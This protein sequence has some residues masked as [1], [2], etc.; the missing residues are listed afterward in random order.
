MLV[1]EDALDIG[2]VAAIHCFCKSG[3]QKPINAVGQIP[4]KA[5][6]RLSSCLF[7]QKW[8]GLAGHFLTAIIT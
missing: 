5:V 1:S 3:E 4:I 8:L 7:F 2:A 6:E